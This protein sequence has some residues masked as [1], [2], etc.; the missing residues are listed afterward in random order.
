[1]ARVGSRARD[2]LACGGGD[3]GGVAGGADEEGV[4]HE[5]GV[6]GD[7]LVEGAEED[8]TLV[9]AEGAGLGVFDYSD[10]LVSGLASGDALADGIFVAEEFLGEGLVNDGDMGAG[11]AFVGEVAAGEAG[12][13]H[14]FEVAG[15][16]HVE[17]S[18]G[19]GACGVRVAFDLHAVAA[20]SPGEWDGVGGDSGDYAGDGCNPL[21][22]LVEELNGTL[23]GVAVDAGIDR[24]HEDAAG[25]EADVDAG[26]G[27]EAAKEETG[28]AEENERHGD[29]AD[30]EDVAEIEAATGAGEGVFAF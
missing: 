15:G 13:A 6:G 25:A 22:G 19:P 29:L 12:D 24:H 21:T 5:G 10:D 14:G 23:R 18:D 20:A 8:V 7:G 1:M 4:A 3:G 17:L 28:G 16:G 30:E 26:G 27:L 11:R 2:L 9:F